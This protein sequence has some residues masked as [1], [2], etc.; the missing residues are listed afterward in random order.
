MC[1][2]FGDKGMVNL[3]TDVRCIFYGGKDRGEQGF[4]FQG[5]K[6]KPGSEGRYFWI[7]SFMN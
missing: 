2:C 1:W 7:W 5:G 4:S 3:L 6:R